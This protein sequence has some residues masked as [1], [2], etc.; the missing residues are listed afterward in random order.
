ML[1]VNEDKPLFFHGPAAWR[2][3]NSR[4]SHGALHQG[5]IIL[6]GFVDIRPAAMMA[7]F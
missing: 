6:A 7:V 2:A 4:L 5:S 1:K 3:D